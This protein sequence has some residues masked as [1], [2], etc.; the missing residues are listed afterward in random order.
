MK[1]TL[2]LLLFTLLCGAA[3]AQK[4]DIWFSFYNKDTTLI[5]FKDA[6]GK[7]MIRPKFTGFTI[8]ARFNHIIAAT[9]EKNGQWESY[10]LTRTGKIVGRDSLYIFDNAPDC[11]NEGFIRFRDRKTDKTGL[12]NREGNI[13]VPAEYNDM[14]QVRNGMIIALK[15][16]T[17]KTDGEHYSWND[18]QEVLIDTLNH[19]LIDS[20]PY[21]NNINLYSLR[22]SDNPDPDTTRKSFKTVKGQYFSF[23]DYDKEFHA[24]LHAVLQNGFSKEGLAQITN[25]QIAI[26]NEDKGWSTESGK[27][28]TERNAIPVSKKLLLLHTAGTDYQVFSETFAYPIDEL[29]QYGRYIDNCGGLKYWQYPVMGLVIN[30][31]YKSEPVQDNFSFLRTANGYRLVSVTVRDQQ[32]K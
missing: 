18:G 30:Y 1:R 14:S 17:K 8:A 3:C 23:I 15:G 20:F 21:D 11:E 19:L 10:Y 32:L 28:F 29:P 9:E 6:K 22:I 2:I 12:L 4:T 24:W 16:A 26:W 31:T 27:T 25:G 7:V 13:A 5:G